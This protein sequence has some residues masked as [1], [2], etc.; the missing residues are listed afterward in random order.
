VSTSH[1]AQ[2][3]PTSTHKANK[4][5]GSPTYLNSARQ[6][7]TSVLRAHRIT[8][9]AIAQTQSAARCAYLWKLRKFA[10]KLNDALQQRLL[11][12]AARTVHDAK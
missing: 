8:T 2:T 4:C 10:Q 12:L 9:Y 6:Y 5:C 1:I 3:P 7:R 11:V